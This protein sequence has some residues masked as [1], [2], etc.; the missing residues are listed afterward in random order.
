MREGARGRCEHEG[1]GD[2]VSMKGREEGCADSE[3]D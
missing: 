1:E 3:S 2:V